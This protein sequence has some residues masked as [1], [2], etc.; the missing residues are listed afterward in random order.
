MCV[1]GDWGDR[2]RCHSD[3]TITHPSSVVTLR[4]RAAG[5]SIPPYHFCR[6]SHAL[7]TR[8]TTSVSVARYARETV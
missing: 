2:G 1:A 8:V 4:R 3:A 7:T 6:F 5:E